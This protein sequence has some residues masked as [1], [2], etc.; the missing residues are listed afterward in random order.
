MKN[1]EEKAYG[2]SWNSPL[3]PEIKVGGQMSGNE[4]FWVK[5]LPNGGVY[6]NPVAY[7]YYSITY[8]AP[9][10]AVF[11][12]FKNPNPGSGASATPDYN[13]AP[14]TVTAPGNTTPDGKTVPTGYKAYTFTVRNEIISPKELTV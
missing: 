4:S 9:K 11:E 14:P 8:L 7:Q 12:G 5:P 3:N 1:E 10:D 2:K 13:G 6:T